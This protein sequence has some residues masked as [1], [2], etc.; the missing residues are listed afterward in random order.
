MTVRT[1]HIL[2]SGFALCAPLTACNV[3][4]ESVVTTADYLGIR[5]DISRMKRQ[6]RTSQGDPQENL[7]VRCAASSRRLL[8]QRFFPGPDWA[9]LRARH[10]TSYAGCILRGCLLC[11]TPYGR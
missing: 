4:T 9:V 5:L 2:L 1:H 3:T 6:P 8:T 7:V 11:P 10:K